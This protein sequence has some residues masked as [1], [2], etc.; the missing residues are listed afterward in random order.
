MTGTVYPH[1]PKPTDI[2][3]IVEQAKDH[4]GSCSGRSRRLT[5]KSILLS[6]LARLGKPMVTLA[7]RTPFDL[8]AYPRSATHAH[9][10]H[11]PL[12]TP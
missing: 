6:D 2:A 9:G 10:S 8:A 4:D 7:L 11:R 12:S 1:N 3:A 5:G